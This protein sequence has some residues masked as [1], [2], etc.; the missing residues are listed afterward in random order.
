MQNR[1]TATFFLTKAMN[2]LPAS[3]QISDWQ[4]ERASRLHRACLA[5]ETA[6]KNG[7]KICKSIRHVASGHNARQFK[8]DASRRM[9]LSAPTLRRMWQVWRRGG[10]LPSAFRLKYRP[11]RA[12]IPAPVLIRFTQFVAATRQ[13][14]LKKAWQNFSNRPGSFCRAHNSR[15]PVKISYCQLCRYFTA[16]NF[17]RLQAHL[18]A[19]QTEQLNLAQLRLAITADIRRQ[20][21]DQLPGRR[22]GREITFEI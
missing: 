6:I 14:S 10:R 11:V 4:T 7:G 16:A 20:L 21:P 2:I 5:L 22:V 19:I 8:S 17:Y 1:F 3:N 9:Q 15:K 18:K 13:P 12:A